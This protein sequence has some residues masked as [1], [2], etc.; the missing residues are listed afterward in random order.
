M[1]FFTKSS[2][3]PFRFYI[4]YFSMV[5][6]VRFCVKFASSTGDSLAGG[7]RCHGRGVAGKGG[8]RGLG[9]I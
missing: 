2:F 8:Y 7:R 9:M 3:F 5:K 1:I 6:R 4:L